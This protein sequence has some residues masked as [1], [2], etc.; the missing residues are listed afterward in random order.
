MSFKHLKVPLDVVLPSVPSDAPGLRYE[1]P[2]IGNNYWVVDDFFDSEEAMSIRSS[3][4]NSEV[5]KFGKPYTKELWPGMRTP[6]ALSDLQL[7]KVE[8]YVKSVIKK[9]KLWVAKSDKVVVDTNT[10][11]LV[12]ADEG[13]SRPH[14]DNRFL[15]RYAAVLYLSPNPKPS[16]GTSFYRLKYANEAAGG[17]IVDPPFANLV[18]ALNVTSLPYS[19][20]YKDIDIDNRFNRLIVFKGNIVHS[21]SKYFGDD[22]NTKRLAVTFFWMCED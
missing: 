22:L 8:E 14:V 21:A 2:S 9:D 1:K 17:N 3:C 18:D 4:L 13:A 15:C 7:N 5:W 12:G 11:I 10:A 6:D 16:A 19:A 20:W